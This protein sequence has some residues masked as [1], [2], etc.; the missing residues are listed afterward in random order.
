MPDGFKKFN[1]RLST[2][3]EWVGLIAVL[4]MILITCVDV[5][6]AKLFLR[7]VFG[8]IDIVMIAQLIAITFAA[9]ATLLAG[10]HVQVE[11]FMMMLPKKPQAIVDAFV[12]LV[13]LGLFALMFW[14]L[15]LY[16]RTLQITGEVSS[17]A[18]IPLHYFAYGVALSFIP[19]CLILIYNL[20]QSI[21]MKGST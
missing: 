14:R 21:R 16:A 19:V 5:I 2:W 7:P 20:I 18:R 9:A 6:G 4:L 13:G 11:F 1:A 17:T 15:M 12:H 3:M 10:R 8:A